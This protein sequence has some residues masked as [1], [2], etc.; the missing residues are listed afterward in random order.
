MIVY[1]CV[2]LYAMNICLCDELLL[3]LICK[4]LWIK[5]SISKNVNVININVMLYKSVKEQNPN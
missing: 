5:V 3:F 1:V 4:L 2:L